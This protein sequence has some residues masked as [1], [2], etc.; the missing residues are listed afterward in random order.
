M[1][2]VKDCINPEK[3]NGFFN[4]YLDEKLNEHRK[5]FEALG[6]KMHVED[7]ANQLSGFGFCATKRATLTCKVIGSTER[8]LKILF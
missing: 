3:P 4:E 6:N 8:I 1:F 2:M 5:V 7:D